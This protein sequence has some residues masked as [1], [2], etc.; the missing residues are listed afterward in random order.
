MSVS[1]GLFKSKEYSPDNVLSAGSASIAN[2]GGVLNPLKH[3]EY[4]VVVVPGIYPIV[5]ADGRDAQALSERKVRST[6]LRTNGVT[7]EIPW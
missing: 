7:D 4:I 2:L 5:K 3:S 1:A 6:N